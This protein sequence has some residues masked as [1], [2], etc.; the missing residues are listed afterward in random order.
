MLGLAVDDLEWLLQLDAT[1]HIYI[2]TPEFE[3][4]KKM[5]KAGD[6]LQTQL[7]ML[8]STTANQ[9]HPERGIGQRAHRRLLY[10]LLFSIY[11]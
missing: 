6:H 8:E 7:P 10:L 11:Y 3:S 5:T 4:K 1:G 2:R 9:F